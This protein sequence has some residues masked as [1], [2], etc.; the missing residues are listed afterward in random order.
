M[1]HAAAL[2]ASGLTKAFGSLVAVD[3][4]DLTVRRGQILALLGPNGAGKTTAL[5]MLCGLMPPDA[6]HVLL[7]GEPAGGKVIRRRI[8][9]CPQQVETWD[10]L[11]C[12]EQLAF[13][14]RLYGIDRRTLEVRSGRLLGD[15]GL[16]SKA[17]TQA[18]HLSGGMARRL[19]LALALVHDPDILAL[20]EP[21]AGLDPQSRVLIRD[22]IAGLAETK[23]ILL[24]SHNMDEVE[25]VADVVAI[26]DRGVV[27]VE[28]SPDVLRRD[29]GPVDVLEIRADGSAAEAVRDAVGAAFPRCELTVRGDVLEVRAPDVGS[30]VPPLV[31]TLRTEGVAYRELRLRQATLEDVFLRLTGTELRP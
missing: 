20:D 23:A 9:V 31:D 12:R 7:D 1:S 18:R 3:S 21:E 11:T 27:L 30:L 29:H 2:G 28:G 26:M 14:G 25:R 5:T 13:V 15:L 17:G 8:G 24:T 4:L 16:G 22:Y 10:R 19:N 6:G